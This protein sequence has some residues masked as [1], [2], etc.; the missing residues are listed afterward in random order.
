MNVFTINGFIFTKVPRTH[1]G[2]RTDSSIN[3]IGTTGN[4]HIEE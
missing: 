2:E 3:A 4:P 1:N